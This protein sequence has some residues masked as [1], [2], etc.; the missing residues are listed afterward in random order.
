[1]DPRIGTLNSGKFY[2][3]ANGHHAEPVVGTLRAV[4]AALGLRKRKLARTYT[5]TVAPGCIAW[6]AAPYSFEVDASDRSAAIKQARDQY[7][8]SFGVRSYGPATIRAKLAK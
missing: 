4:E 2:A 3:Y 5:V 1:M 8:E 7:E 6:N